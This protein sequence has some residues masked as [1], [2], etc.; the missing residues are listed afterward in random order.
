MT[1]LKKELMILLESKDY[2]SVI[3]VLNS[4]TR[5]YC[6]QMSEYDR[7]RD[8][9]PY[10]TDV[11][12]HLKI[13]YL[14]ASFINQDGKRYIAC[15]EPKANY[16]SLF[17]QFISKSKCDLILSLKGEVNYFSHL[18]PITVETL[19]YKE[20]DF[21]VNRQ[22]IVNGNNVK[23]ITCLLWDDKT[24][25]EK[26]KIDELLKYYETQNPKN[27]IIHCLA[28]VGRTGSFIMYMLLHNFKGTITK[29]IFLD[30]LISLRSQRYSMVET[31]SQLKFL[32]ETFVHVFKG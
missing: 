32:F 30:Y 2:Q 18:E 13:E 12:D 22:Y 19:K 25:M 7:F 31:D 11:S 23:S 26:A 21:L 3:N 20:K 1:D 10:N 27:P 8:M 14:N 5:K 28:G 17:L 4:A 24:M 29:E 9:T 6:I 15:Q 16:D